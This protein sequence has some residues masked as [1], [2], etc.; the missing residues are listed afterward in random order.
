MLQFIVLGQIPGTQT[1]VDLTS[2][3]N[4]LGSVIIARLMYALFR[5]AIRR[6]FTKRVQF[7]QLELIT[8]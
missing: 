1:Y 3:L 4:I 2:I 7:I 8:L 6:A 5:R